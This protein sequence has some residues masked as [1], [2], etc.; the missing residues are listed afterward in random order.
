VHRLREKEVMAIT[1]VMMIAAEGTTG[2]TMAVGMIATGII[3][4]AHTTAA[5]PHQPRL[6]M[7]NQRR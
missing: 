2:C 6:S 4:E 3:T 5:V 7:L 1:V